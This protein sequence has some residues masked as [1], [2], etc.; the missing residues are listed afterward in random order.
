VA[1]Y[2][3]L[4]RRIARMRAEGMSLHAIADGLNEEGVPM[5]RGGAK[6]R[7]WSVQ[8]AVGLPPAP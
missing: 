6:W 1:D 2:P 8:A 5:V 4:Q 3:E 7:P